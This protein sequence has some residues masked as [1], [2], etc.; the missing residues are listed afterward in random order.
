MNKFLLI[1]IVLLFLFT[2]AS[3]AVIDDPLVE[4]H[5]LSGANNKVFVESKRVNDSFS[6]DKELVRLKLIERIKLLIKDR[7]VTENTITLKAK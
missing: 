1:F 5:S 3:A 4:N 7:A 6:I 2:Y